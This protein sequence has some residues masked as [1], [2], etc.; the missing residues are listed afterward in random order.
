MVNFA[1]AYV[2]AARNQW[3][4]DRAAEQAR[5]NTPPYGGLYIGQPDRAKAALDRWD[6][7]HP[8]P[9]ATLEQ[10]ATDAAYAH[11][12]KLADRME[13]GLAAILDAAGLP[14]HVARCGARVEIVRAPN[15]LSRARS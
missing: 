10:V 4:A 2:S 11:M 13:A 9:V 8:K 5:S 1:P 12:E 6:R 7:E 3:E 14:W 15:P